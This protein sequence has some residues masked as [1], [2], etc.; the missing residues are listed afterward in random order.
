[1]ISSEEAI[2]E[3]LR[4]HGLRSTPQRRVILTTL[5]EAHGEHLSADEVHIRAQLSMPTIG[6][7][8]VYTTLT[9]LTEIGALSAV[10][11]PEP[12]RY[13]ANT[14][15]H[16]HFRC[17]VCARLFDLDGEPATLGELDDDRFEV[18]RVSVHAEGVCA[19]CRD[20]QAGLVG[21][22]EA[23]HGDGALP[24]SDLLA[25]PGLACARCDGPLGQ[26]LLAATTA[27]LV[28]LAFE[29]HADAG[30]LRELSRGRRGSSAARAHLH[31]AM[32]GLESFLAGA[33]E[34]IDC[35]V[36]DE[37]L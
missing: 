28:R 7:G 3:L 35:A 33:G 26:I 25:G 1:M 16:D 14:S 17:R 29:D 19:D 21:G 4:A 6:R 20:Y 12:V 36:D 18:E 22:V 34:I 31:A 24:W 23:I 32:A 13:E 15:P 2:G 8:T 37:A 11:L 10:G 5:E 30:Q 9:E 27:G